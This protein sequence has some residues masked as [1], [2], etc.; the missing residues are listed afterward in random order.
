MNEDQLPRPVV[1]PSSPV[2]TGNGCEPVAEV[3]MVLSEAVA[4]AA[5]GA[6]ARRS[7]VADGLLRGGVP[8]PDHSF[9]HLLLLNVDGRAAY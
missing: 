1:V 3:G 6:V 4:I 7:E 8:G 5:H 9:E 2:F